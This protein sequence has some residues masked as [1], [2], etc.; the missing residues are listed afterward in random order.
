MLTPGSGDGSAIWQRSFH[1]D[2][3]DVIF[4]G[5]QRNEE[6]AGDLLVGQAGGHQAGDF[7]FAPR[8]AGQRNVRPGVRDAQY[9]HGLAQIAR[10]LEVNGHARAQVL[11]G[12]SSKF[13][14]W[15]PPAIL[16]MHH[17]HQAPQ[18]RQRLRIQ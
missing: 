2:A 11:R 6:L 17:F 16:D 1:Q 5:C 10:R 4:Y 12:E 18:A 7:L 15:N 9:D 3:V 13:G 8:Q 14:K